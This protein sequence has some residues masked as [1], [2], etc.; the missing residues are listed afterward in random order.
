MLAAAN[1]KATRWMF[2]NVFCGQCCTRL[3]FESIM[4]HTQHALL[5]LASILHVHSSIDTQTH[6]CNSSSSVQRLN[7]DQNLL[8]IMLSHL[9]RP[10]VVKYSAT[11]TSTSSPAA[12]IAAVY[13]E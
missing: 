9:L 6:T 8:F 11:A 2:A 3:A 1:A 10:R 4:S 7:V 5:L 13:R 12:S